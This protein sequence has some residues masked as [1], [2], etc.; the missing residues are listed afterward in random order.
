[1]PILYVC[2]Q[3]IYYMTRYL[4]TRNSRSM[5]AAGPKIDPCVTPVLI[6]GNYKFCRL[7]SV[8]SSWSLED[9]V[10]CSPIQSMLANL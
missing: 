6:S 10:K 5:N 2:K 3:F 8:I 9:N 4:D 1:M 7:Y